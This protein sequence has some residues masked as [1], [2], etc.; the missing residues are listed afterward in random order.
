[1]AYDQGRDATSKQLR[2]LPLFSFLQT[3]GRPKGRPA[4]HFSIIVHGIL[5][6]WLLHS[7]RPV[8]LAPSSGGFGGRAVTHLYWPA[9]SSQSAGASEIAIRTPRTPLKQPRL[10]YQPAK[11]EEQAAN[12]IP[13]PPLQA[14][15]DETSSAPGPSAGSTHGGLA[16]GPPGEDVRPALPVATFEPAVDPSSLAGIAE[17][18]CIVEITIDETGAVVAQSVVQSM[19]PAIDQAVLVAVSHW[20]FRPATRDGVPIPSKQDVVYHFKPRG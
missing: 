19:G 17:G 18:N 9:A 1:M 10:H 16:D 12:R 8:F 20:H 4:L 15:E 2:K 7:P 3:D 11:P 6:V 14:Q 5:L 13:E